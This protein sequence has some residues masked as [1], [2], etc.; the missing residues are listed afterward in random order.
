MISFSFVVPVYNTGKYL[1]ECLESLLRESTNCEILLVDDGSTDGVSAELCDDY[2]A[3]HECIRAFHTENRGPGAARNYGVQKA[4]G[5]YIVLVDSDDYV[6][7]GLIYA[8][9]KYCEANPCDLI[10]YPIRKFFPDGKIESESGEYDLHLFTFTGGSLLKELPRDVT[11]LSGGKLLR[12]SAES[13]AMFSTSAISKRKAENTYHSK[14]TEKFI[15]LRSPAR[16][17]QPSELTG[18]SVCAIAFATASY[19]IFAG[20]SSATVQTE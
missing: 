7:D 13:F 16:I 12:L 14:K 1:P 3:K 10:F 19:K 18:S 5:D 2:A 11:V 9:R 17:M 20:T 8:A 4:A 15:S 6:E